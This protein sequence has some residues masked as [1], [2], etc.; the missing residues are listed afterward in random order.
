MPGVTVVRDGDFVGVAAPD[1]PAAA[2]ALAALQAEW[3][4]DARSRP[5]GTCSTYFKE[6]PESS[7]GARRPDRP[8]G[9]ARSRTGWPRP[10]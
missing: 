3:T 9:P 1:E 2:Q 10:T 7:A 6:H 8:A 5:T 4:D